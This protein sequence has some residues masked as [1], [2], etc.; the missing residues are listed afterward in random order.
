M[1]WEALI[2]PSSAIVMLSPATNLFCLLG[3]WYSLVIK[4]LSFVSSLVLVGW[5][6]LITPSAIVILVPSGLTKPRVEVVA[7]GGA[8]ALITLLLLSI[9]ILSPAVS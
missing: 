3:S 7:V 6:E 8:L 9:V 1:G 4:P 2:V 5:V